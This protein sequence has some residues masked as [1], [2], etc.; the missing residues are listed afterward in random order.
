MNKTI[1]LALVLPF[2]CVKASS[3]RLEVVN[4]VIDCGQIEYRSPV[5]A[6]FEVRNKSNRR[7]RISEVK[8]SCGCTAV[9]FPRGEIASDGNFA[10]RVTYDAMQMGSFDKLVDVY[11][12][13]EKKPLELRLKGKVVREIR[14]FSGDY[15]LTVESLSVDKD[16]LE[17]DDVNIGDRPMQKIHVRNSTSS[18]VQ[19]VVMHLPDYMTADVSPSKIAPGHSGVITVTL[20][21]KR[22]KDYGL[23]Q[24]TVYLGTFPGDKVS[25]EKEIGISAVLLPKFGNLTTS[26][27]A[28]APRIKLSTTELD[29]GK[30]SGKKKLKGEIV[31][32]NEGYSTLEI[33]N[34]QMFTN[35]LEVS[36]N[37]SKIEPGEEAKLKIT[38]VAKELNTARRPRVL[39]ITNDPSHPKVIVK[40]TAKL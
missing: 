30:F 38:V 20:N 36:L 33:N 24:T 23:T 29:L 25:P 3:Q 4:D 6:E 9:E 40:V 8:T 32:S 2:L 34:M 7:I 18:P 15:P 12:S 10:V 31:I 35:G 1:Y 13:S 37:K 39:I 21:S 11:T 17:F 27:L 22:L 26:E 5:T 28:R 14:D 16:E 19:P